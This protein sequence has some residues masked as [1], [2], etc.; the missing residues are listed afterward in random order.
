METRH[1]FNAIFAVFFLIIGGFLGYLF[2]GSMI[3][4][5][6]LHKSTVDSL[7]MYLL[8]ALVMP[9]KSKFHCACLFIGMITGIVLTSYPPDHEWVILI[10]VVVLLNGISYF[11]AKYFR[12]L[13]NKF[14]CV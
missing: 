8:L 5:G 12:P 9:I 2:D 7:L 14:Y 11:V 3:S 4:T 6:M 13:I 10:L 1:W